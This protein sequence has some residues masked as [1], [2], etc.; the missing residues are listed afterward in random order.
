MSSNRKDIKSRIKTVQNTQKVTKSM[1]LIAIIKL[2]QLQNLLNSSKEYAKQV[3][4]LI[5]KSFQQIQQD[6]LDQNQLTNLVKNN[7]ST[8]KAYKLFIVVSSD[9]GLCGPFN[10][11]L[12]KSLINETSAGNS[13]KVKFI[14][15]GNKAINFIQ[16]TYGDSSIE[17]R[18]GNLSLIPE[19]ELVSEI[20]D[21]IKTKFLSG[22]I[23]SAQIYFNSFVSMVK[24][25]I[26]DHFL[27]PFGQ[28]IEELENNKNVVSNANKTI[29][30]SSNESPTDIKFEP[31]LAKTLEIL[32]PIYIENTIY[33]A[34]IASRTGELANRVTAMTAA[35]DNANSLISQLTLTYNKARQASITQE[36]SEIVAAAESLA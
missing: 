15:L 36:I 2:K 33:Q 25:E 29:N 31:D 35:S 32:L 28:V 14:V 20:T 22:E 34:L 27:L 3:K 26:K 10:S 1:K 16:K 21:I 8:E 11:H 30:N 12:F 5:K 17:E 4:N 6:S 23:L 24:S 13:S 19:K 18:Y 7:I 9:R